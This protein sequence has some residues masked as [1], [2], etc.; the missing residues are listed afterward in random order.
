[1]P[2][3]FREQINRILSTE[4]SARMVF[5]FVRTQAFGLQHNNPKDLYGV[6]IVLGAFHK[7]VSSNL[8]WSEIVKEADTRFNGW[9][10][11]SIGVVSQPSSSGHAKRVIKKTKK[12]ITDLARGRITPNEFDPYMHDRYCNFRE[13]IRSKEVYVENREELEHKYQETIKNLTS[14]I[15]ELKNH[16]QNVPTGSGR[17]GHNNPP[18]DMSI[19]VFSQLKVDEVARSLHDLHKI[20][21]TNPD[22]KS[23]EILTNVSNQFRQY[24]ESITSYICRKLDLAID[25][26]SKEA[27]KKAAQVAGLGIFFSVA[28]ELNTISKVALDLATFIQ[29]LF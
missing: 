23:S 2:S 24:A 26:F 3:Q 20:D 22:K 8:E 11:V 27:G 16:I 18:E 10:L 21:F 13:P 28:F 6:P 5:V 19:P 15:D 12:N 7:I 4:E 29:K 25:E 17:M 14:K 1:M 9:N